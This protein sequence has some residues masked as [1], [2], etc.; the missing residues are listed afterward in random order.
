[1]GEAYAKTSI[2]RVE[3]RLPFCCEGTPDHDNLLDE[4]LKCEY[5][6]NFE[7]YKKGNFS[8]VPHV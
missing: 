4:Q 6:M 8:L 7:D 2:K 1:M 5:D 3:G